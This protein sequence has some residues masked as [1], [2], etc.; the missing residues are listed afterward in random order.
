MAFD[1]IFWKGSPD[2]TAELVWGLLSQGEAVQHIKKITPGEA[3]D[4]FR[5]EFGPK[6]AYNVAAGEVS[7]PGFTFTVRK[8]SGYLQVWCEDEIEQ[9]THGQ[10]TLQRVQRA[11]QFRLGCQMYN[12][13]TGDYAET[14]KPEAL[15]EAVAQRSGM[16]KIELGVGSRIEHKKFGP[17]KI[18]AVFGAGEKCQAQVTFQDGSK[19][20]LLTRFLSPSA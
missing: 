17:G 6:V 11:A 7:G 12:P 10:S 5:A 4:A 2:E 9:A 16:K 3:V 15:E 8:K 20:K 19:R 18:T 14:T 13:A 1:L